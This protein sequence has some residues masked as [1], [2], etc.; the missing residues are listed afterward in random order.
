VLRV[1]IDDLDE[2]YFAQQAVRVLHGQVP[3]REFA[4]LYTPGL[5]YVHAGMFAVLGGPSLVEM[6]MLALAARAGLALLLFALA[7]P[8]MRNSFW[9]AAPA[10]VLLLGLDDA[11]VRWEPHPGWLSTFFALLAV[12]CLTFR[13]SPPWLLAA[14]LAT[15]A[16]YLFKQN[17]GV[18]ILAAVLL[19]SGRRRFLVP[20]SAF[21]VASV[22]WLV[23]LGLAVDGQL[24]QLAVLVGAVNQG[25]LLSAP[26]PTLLIPL[27]CAAGGVWLV[28]RDSAPRLRLY[29]LTG[30]ALF[31]TELPRMDTLH[32]MWSAPILLVLGAASLERLRPTVRV[33]SLAVVAVLLAPTV[34]S[35]LEYLAQPLTLLDGVEG[36]PQTVSE[37]TGVVLDIQ[38]RTQP[39]EPVFVYPTS[40]LLYELADRP[41]PTRFDHLN[42][43]AATPDEIQQVIA[44]LQQS[45]VRLVVISDFWQSVWGPPGPNA[46]LEEWLKAHY[47]EV[48][49]DGPY[50]VLV[51]L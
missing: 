12:W 4:T 5:A 33:L 50:R 20:L 42:P 24:Q 29:L 10:L 36:P 43:G 32:L 27:A 35:R 49:R 40:P 17:T 30:T 9:A 26:E 14:G 41:N 45:N 7:R 46:P 18:F 38:Q 22:V 21:A 1:G 23:P 13:P 37:L 16:S 51:A 2:G 25:S 3:Y 28:R 15:A 8:L 48:A 19:W 34:S 44:D 31:L 47:A 11:P 6:R 39:G